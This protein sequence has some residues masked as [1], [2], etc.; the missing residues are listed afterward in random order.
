VP[1]PM[2]GSGDAAVKVTI[3]IKFALK[4]AGG[5]SIINYTII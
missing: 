3:L 5:H 4:G 2:L 1:S